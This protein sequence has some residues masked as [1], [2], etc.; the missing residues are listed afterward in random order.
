MRS[1]GWAVACALDGALCAISLD[2]ARGASNPTASLGRDILWMDEI[3]SHFET[4]VETIVCWFFTGESS[5]V[6]D[7]VHPQW[8]GIVSWLN[9][10]FLGCWTHE[11]CL[12][13][14]LD[15]SRLACLIRWNVLV[16]L[17]TKQLKAGLFAKVAQLCLLSPDCKATNKLYF[18]VC[19]SC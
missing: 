2:E 14:W 13:F 19:V 17:A 15:L 8:G 5:L 18:I 16:V 7:F 6:Q 4:M 10:R 3:R 9:L 12:P 11:S 1:P